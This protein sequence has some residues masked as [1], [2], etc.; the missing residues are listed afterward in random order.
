MSKLRIKRA[1]MGM[2]FIMS[3]DSSDAGIEEY[4]LASPATLA[5]EEMLG[6]MKRALKLSLEHADFKLWAMEPFV[7][8]IAKA[9]GK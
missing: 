8:A 5:A 2:A 1:A 3:E 7:Q 9:E 4:V 6:L